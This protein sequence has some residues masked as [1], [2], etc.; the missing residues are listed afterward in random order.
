MPGDRREL[1]HDLH[2]DKSSSQKKRIQ[3]LH[4]ATQVIDIQIITMYYITS[5]RSLNLYNNSFFM[6]TL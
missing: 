1:T 2:V 4:F 6:H 5:L 3:N